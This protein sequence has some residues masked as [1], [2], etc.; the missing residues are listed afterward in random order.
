MAPR[1]AIVIVS[2]NTA[3][4]LDACLQS[5]YENTVG[6]EFEIIVV[7]NAST[8]GSRRMLKERYPHVRL[9]E[10]SENIGFGPANNLGA[11]ATR[12]PYV[13]FL[14]SDTVLLEDTGAALVRFLDEHPEAGAVGPEVLLM[15]GR[16]QPKTCGNLPRLRPILCQYLLLSCLAPRSRFLS[17]IC[18]ERRRQRVTEV[19]WVSAVSVVV[20]AEAFEEGGGFDPACFMYAEEIDLFQRMARRGWKVYRVEDYALKHHLGASS[21]SESQ[22]LR[23]SLM[24]QRNLMRVAARNSRRPT[25]W[26]IR[27]AMAVGLLARLAVG[28]VAAIGSRAFR[29]RVRCWAWGLADLFGLVKKLPGGDRA[30]R[31]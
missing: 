13:W 18:V 10:N 16:P 15:D 23:N 1:L 14:N 28:A 19:G 20:R 29:F 31:D 21:K 2:Y 12:A 26:V 11:A 22:H 25:Q 24:G 4:L 17:G 7:D 27:A 3:D 8:D 5:V 6:V 9:I 30:D